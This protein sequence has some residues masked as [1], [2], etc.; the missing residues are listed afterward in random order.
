MRAILFFVNILFHVNLIA[1]EQT[2]GA[3]GLN[4]MAVELNYKAI[5]VEYEAS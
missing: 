1:G 2:P 5:W 3:V 4:Q